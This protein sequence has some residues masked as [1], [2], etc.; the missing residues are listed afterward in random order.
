M[1]KIRDIKWNKKLD[2][3]QEDLQMLKGWQRLFVFSIEV[4]NWDT[5]LNSF[6]TNKIYFTQDDI[7]ILDY[8][9]D[10]GINH[11]D[12]NTS[13]IFTFFFNNHYHLV[14]FFATPGDKGFVMFRIDDIRNNIKEVTNLKMALQDFLKAGHNVEIMK[15]AI[16]QVE[17]IEAAGLAAEI[18]KTGK[19]ITG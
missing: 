2:K 7:E 8:I 10:V 9:T 6:M 12:D 17:I 18:F 4:V 1:C 19:P 15:K 16:S 14:L 11:V 5:N 13:R 3:Y